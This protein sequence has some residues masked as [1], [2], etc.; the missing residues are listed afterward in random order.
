M[1]DKEMRVNIKS[2]QVIKLILTGFIV[3]RRFRTF[4]KLSVNCMTYFFE[5][6]GF[7]ESYLNYFSVNLPLDFSE[8]FNTFRIT[9]LLLFLRIQENF[10]KNLRLI[11][12][13]KLADERSNNF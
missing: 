7:K 1:F 13:S 5:P 11:V 4:K 2:Y 6:N 3:E 8:I 12:I 10:R 9:V